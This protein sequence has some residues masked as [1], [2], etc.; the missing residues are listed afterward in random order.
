MERQLQVPTTAGAALL[1]LIIDRDT[2]AALRADKG[3][4]GG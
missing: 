3:V 1:R 2:F 4:D